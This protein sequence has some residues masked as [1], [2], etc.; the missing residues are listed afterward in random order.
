M[1]RIALIHATRVAMPP[2]EAAFAAG[3]PAAETI[4]ILE[5]GL[6][7]D[8]ASGRAQR[9]ELDARINALADYAMGLAPDAILFTCSSF[10]TG[11]E[12]AASR[13]PLPVLKPNEAMFDA[14]LSVGGR[15]T[16]LYSFPP[17]AE[18]MEREFRAAA[19][20]AGSD[21]RITSVLVPGALDAIKAGD[22]DRHNQMVAD[23]AREV[24]ETDAIMLAHFSMTPAV[25][26]V[27]QTTTIPVLTSPETAIAKL[28][29]IIERIGQC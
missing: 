5:E 6:S 15:I 20:Q 1:P 17:A 18:S 22:T 16:M 28:Q 29:A 26:M 24:S 11:I 27:R 7:S 9:S 4:S 3:W 21:A 23:V 10:G 19:A 13:L 8:L 14:A 2:V 12:Q 25:G